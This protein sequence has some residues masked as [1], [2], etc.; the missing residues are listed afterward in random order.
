MRHK[1]CKRLY[2]FWQSRSTSGDLPELQDFFGEAAPGFREH[3]VVIVR[4]AGDV[5]FDYCGDDVL[6]ALGADILGQSM[7]FCYSEKFKALQLE[8][9]SICFDQHVGLDRYSR[10][11]FG[12]RHKD[13]EWLMLPV[14]DNIGD[15]IVLIGM[16]AT[17]VEHDTLDALVVGSDMIERVIAQ[18]YLASATE[19]D[20]GGI[21]RKSWAMLDAMGADVTVNGVPVKRSSASFGGEAA[22]AARKASVA[23]VLAVTERESFLRT[24]EELR[25]RYSFKLVETV[26]EAISVLRKD[27][28]DVLLVDERVRGGT[29]LDIIKEAQDR[30]EDTAC[31]LMLEPRHAAQD[32]V[33]RTERGLVYCLVKPVGEF[34][35]RKAL[36]DAGKYVTSRQKKRFYDTQVSPQ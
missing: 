31:V 8:S 7:T 14:R 18:D 25:G 3:G 20:F 28:V 11:W 32:T 2:K 29:G 34:A 13:V 23:T 10:F 36:D 26:G 16:A 19:I 30:G 6:K 9:A 15:R 35:L 17:F 12:H 33:V 4:E 1:H 27:R 21:S 22:Y 5:F 24:A